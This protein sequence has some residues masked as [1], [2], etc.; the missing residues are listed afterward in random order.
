MKTVLLLLLLLPLPQPRPPFFAA[1]STSEPVGRI[2][3]GRE[4]AGRRK[5]T[6]TK[7]CYY[8]R[9][10]YAVVSRVFETL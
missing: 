2:P 10:S 5:V 9:G 6:T 8:N 7:F 3:H 4:V 1:S